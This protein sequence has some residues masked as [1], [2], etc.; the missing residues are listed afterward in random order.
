MNKLCMLTLALGALTLAVPAQANE[1]AMNKAGC[2][3]C[4]SKDKKVV[5]PA[6]KDVA[7]K[8]KGNA[9]AAKMLAA[10]VRA[11][12]KGV[13]GPVPMPANGVDKISDADLKTAVAFVLAQ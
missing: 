4:H 10:K 8:Y 13:W 12:G 9:E 6:F 11:G 7:A 5:G 3:V 1:A 2:F